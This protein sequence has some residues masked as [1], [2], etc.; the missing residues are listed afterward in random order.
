LG[1]RWDAVG[2]DAGELVVDHQL[3]RVRRSLL[4]REDE[5]ILRVSSRHAPVRERVA[6]DS[7][8][9]DLTACTGKG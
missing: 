3:Q 5:L 9:M 8:D 6:Q 2:F 4:Y 7:V 1:L